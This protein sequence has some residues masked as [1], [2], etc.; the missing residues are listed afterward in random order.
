MAPATAEADDR[1]VRAVIYPS[2]GVARVGTAPTPG[3]SA[4]KCRIPRRCRR[5][6]IAT[7]AGAL[8]RQAA[9]FRLYGVNARARS[10]AS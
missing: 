10:S 1:I 2:I 9:R 6:P 8:K 4:P 3:S 5:A 7:P